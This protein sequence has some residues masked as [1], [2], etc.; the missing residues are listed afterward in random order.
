MVAAGAALDLESRRK[1]RRVLPGFGLT[2][3]YTLTYLSLI[4]L[5]PLSAAFLRAATLFASSAAMARF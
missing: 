1:A 4:V 3:G 2:L 5:I